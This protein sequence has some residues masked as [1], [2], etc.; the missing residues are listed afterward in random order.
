MNRRGPAVYLHFSIP[1]Q[2]KPPA[3][4]KMI[5]I[6]PVCQKHGRIQSAPVHRRSLPGVIALHRT[7]QRLIQPHRHEYRNRIL[8]HANLSVIQVERISTSIRRRRQRAAAALLESRSPADSSAGVVYSK[9]RWTR[10]RTNW[11]SAAGPQPARRAAADDLHRRAPLFQFGWLD[12]VDPL[13]GASGLAHRSRSAE[14]RGRR[15]L[16]SADHRSDVHARTLGAGL[17]AAI[18]IS[19]VARRSSVSFPRSC[20]ISPANP[21]KLIK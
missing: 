16:L 19:A 6:R 15:L 2:L 21:P 5:H 18:W 8:R 7:K 3:P 11:R 12:S 20:S 13:Q 10:G 17:K 9:R 1:I 14:Q 4:A